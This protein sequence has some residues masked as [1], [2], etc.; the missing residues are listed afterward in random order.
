MKLSNASLR[1]WDYGKC[2]RF[3]ACEALAAKGVGFV[4]RPS[5]MP[6]WGVRAVRLRA[7]EKSQ[8]ELFTFFGIIPRHGYGSNGFTKRRRRTTAAACWSTGSGRGAYAE[9]P[10]I[11]TSGPGTLRLRPDCAAGITPTPGTAGRS[12]AA[13]TPTSCVRRRP[14]GSSSAESK[15]W[16]R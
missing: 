11:A 14:C 9:T 7:P 1:V 6:G 2:F 12:S 15:V 3:Y 10:C 5:D 4:D 8:I 13:G 16:T